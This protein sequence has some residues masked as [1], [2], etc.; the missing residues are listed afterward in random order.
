[1]SGQGKFITSLD[2]ELIGLSLYDFVS[3]EVCDIIKNSI[4]TGYVKSN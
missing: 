3:P 4:E 1:M 2:E